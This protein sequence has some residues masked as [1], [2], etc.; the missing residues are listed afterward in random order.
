MDLS[1]ALW[2]GDDWKE[3][4][5]RLKELQDMDDEVLS[6]SEKQE[7]YIL[8]T[9]LHPVSC[10]LC[11]IKVGSKENEIKCPSCG[12]SLVRCVPFVK[13]CEPGWHWNFTEESR[14]KLLELWRS[15][16]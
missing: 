8:Q 10:P 3:N 15:R 1:N 5:D 14:S 6:S 12:I 13:V 4:L 2:A 16:T 9:H 11:E 7:R